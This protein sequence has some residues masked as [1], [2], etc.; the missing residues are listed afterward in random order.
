MIGEREDLHAGIPSCD[1]EYLTLEIG[2]TVGM[3]SHVEKGCLGQCIMYEGLILKRQ[4]IQCLGLSS[5]F[6][7]MREDASK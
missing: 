1:Y 5:M 6:L 4:I 7:M 3:E 2:E